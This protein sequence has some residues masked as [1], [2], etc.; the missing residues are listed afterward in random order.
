MKVQKVNRR[1]VKPEPFV[2][3][4]VRALVGK[5][6]AIPAEKLSLVVTTFPIGGVQ[7]PVHAHIT[8]EEVIYVVQGQGEVWVDGSTLTIGPEDVILILPGTRHTVKNT[9]NEELVLVC[10]FS[11]CDFR[12]D[13]E[14]YDE[15]CPYCDDKGGC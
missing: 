15:L 5:D 9:G 8:A 6:C 4:D 2:G 1:N 10:A 3:R 14:N 13:R 12:K 7:K 11:T